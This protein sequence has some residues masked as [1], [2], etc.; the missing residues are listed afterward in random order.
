MAAGVAMQ[1]E[2]LEKVRIEEQKRAAGELPT[3]LDER[4][5]V[6]YDDP[7]TTKRK[8][9]QPGLT[10]AEIDELRVKKEPAKNAQ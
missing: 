8:Q 4:L 6:E 3:E 2:Y 1:I 9:E 10:Q 7:E 5:P